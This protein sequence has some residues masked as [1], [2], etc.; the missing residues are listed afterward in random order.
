MKKT[1]RWT[2]AVAAMSML[3]LAS[4][5]P[6]ASSSSSSSSSSSISSS[7]GF[8][9]QFAVGTDE[10]TAESLGAGQYSPTFTI[11]L[12]IV[13]PDEDDDIIL[14]NGTVALKSDTMMASEFLKEAVTDKGL[15]QAGINEGFVTTLGD[16]VNNSEQSMYWMFTVNGL[17]PSFGCNTYQMRDGDYMLWTY[18]VV[19]WMAEPVVPERELGDWAFTVGDDEVT[20][21]SLGAGQYSPTFTVNI[22]IVVLD[23]EEDIVLFNGTVALKSD[24]MWASEFLKEAVT[25]KGLAQAGINEGFVTTLGDYVN[26]SEQSMYWMYT[27]NGGTPSF[28][29]N[30][31][32]L[33][34]G[35]YMYWYYGEVAW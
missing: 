8:D 30:G 11:N 32:Q 28:G 20:A 27:I 15:A 31:Y 29:C 2:F 14:Y 35:D 3:A 22:K 17:S 25:D 23:D 4:C 34:D 16:Y 13:V 5:A 12:K 33:R 1:F 10:V 9:W 24:T 6:A 21:E 19:D 18:D 26:N 7:S